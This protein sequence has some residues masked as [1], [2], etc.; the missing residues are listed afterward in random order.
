MEMI[1]GTMV[2]EEEVEVDMIARGGPEVR[3]Y[4]VYGTCSRELTSS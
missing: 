1:G 3:A 4:E 2:E